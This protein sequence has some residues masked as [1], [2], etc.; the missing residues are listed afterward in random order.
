M[1]RYVTLSTLAKLNAKVRTPAWC[2]NAYAWARRRFRRLWGNTRVPITRANIYRWLNTRTEAG[3]YAADDAL[4]RWLD[5]VYG[6]AAG[7]EYWN[8]PGVH[9]RYTDEWD[10]GAQQR[11]ARV[12]CRIVNSRGG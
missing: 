2:P 5:A 6:Y 1:A 12:F 7:D 4:V 3:R 8:V 11:L 9:A 10:R